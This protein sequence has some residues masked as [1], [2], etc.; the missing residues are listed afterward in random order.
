MIQR[1]PRSTRT[2]TLCPYT[3]LFRSRPALRH[4][5]ALSIE[6]VEEVAEGRPRRKFEFRQLLGAAL[7]LLGGRDI[8]DR[9]QQPGRQI[10]KTVGR[11]TRRGLAWKPDQRRE[12]RQNEKRPDRTNRRKRYGLHLRR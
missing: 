9:R 1:P 11:P 3:T 12:E 6:L 10:G 7:D 2:D 8:D 4:A 5:A